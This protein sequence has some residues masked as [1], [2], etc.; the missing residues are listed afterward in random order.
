MSLADGL[1]T[2]SDVVDLLERHGVDVRDVREVAT[3]FD[4]GTV[5]AQLHIAVPVGM[6]LAPDDL[7]ATIDEAH[8]SLDGGDGT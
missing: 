2:V 6:D 8:D 5:T 4:G 7:K 3:D 1:S